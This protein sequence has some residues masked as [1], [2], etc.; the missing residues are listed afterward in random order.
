MKILVEQIMM[1]IIH[2]LV[3]PIVSDMQINFC[4]AQQNPDGNPTNGIVR[5]Q[6]NLQS[7]P[8]YGDEI[9]YDTSGGSTHGIRKNT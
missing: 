7:F 8:L 4:L 5:K 2:H 6:T 1:Q 3:L 9:H